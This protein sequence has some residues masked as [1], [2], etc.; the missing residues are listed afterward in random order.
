MS[1]TAKE[2]AARLSLS[3]SLQQQVFSIPISPAQEQEW[4]ELFLRDQEAFELRLHRHPTPELLALALYLRWAVATYRRYLTIGIPEFVF[5]DTFQDFVFWSK[6]CTRVTGRPGLI[7]WGWN[8]LLLHMK[9]FRLG[10]LEYQPRTLEHDIA[11]GLV[12]L[13]AD[14]PILE[15]HIPA[16]TPLNKHELSASLCSAGPF[17]EQYFQRSFFWFHCHSWL[18]SPTL[19]DLLSPSSGILQFQSFFTIYSEDFL[20]PQAEQRVFGIIQADPQRY[21]EH[22]KLQRAL[23]KHLLA[24]NHVGMGMGIAQR[25]SVESGKKTTE[26]DV[27]I[28]MLYRNSE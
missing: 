2:L 4:N 5:W 16:G 21:S 20:F 12:S 8:A 19:R 7:E 13:T 10:R 27:S 26:S 9:I 3:E 18:L 25:A 24:G 28:S 17:F 14:T 22:T 1:M 23:K 15:I 11:F 6:E